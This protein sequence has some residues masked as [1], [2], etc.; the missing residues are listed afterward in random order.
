MRQPVGD[1]D[2]DVGGRLVQLR[3]R[4]ADVGPLVD[5]AGRQA[6]RQLARQRQVAQ[7]QRR[8]VALRRRA[9][10][11]GC[12]LVA[13]LHQLHLQRHH[14][15]LRVG[16]LGFLRRHVCAGG[17]AQLELAAHGVQQL[18]LG[19]DQR[20][21]GI[22]LGGERGLGQRGRRNVGGQ[23]V[24]GTLQ[25]EALLLGARAVRLDAATDLAPDVEGVGDVHLRVVHR[26]DGRRDRAARR[27]AGLG[28]ARLLPVT[29]ELGGDR[30]QQRP[31]LRQRGLLRLAQR[32]RL[33]CERGGFGATPRPPAPSG[34]ASGT[35][36]TRRQARRRPPRNP[37]YGR[38]RLPPLPKRSRP[39]AAP[40]CSGRSPG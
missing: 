24:G 7:G 15:R 29:A 4:G 27:H 10:D 40:R 3:L 33:R 11:I 14:Q 32:G 39:A 36:P 26:V 9:P 5:Q 18:L 23:H 12:Q 38:R 28:R 20:L 37:G 2:A 6:D 22:D 16:E 17:P 25:G 34:Q 35:A 13:R 31:L 1:R 19:G 8:H 21:L 30:R